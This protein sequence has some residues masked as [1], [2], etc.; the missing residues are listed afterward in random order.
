MEKVIA[1]LKETW[2]LYIIAIWMIGV[3]GFLVQ[4]NGRFDRLQQRV[5]KLVSDVDAIESILASTDH[6][7]AEVKKTV[8]ALAPQI[9]T[10]HKRVMRR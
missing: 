2:K 5:L 6:N 4:L 7:V 9:V 10:M 3:T 1:H 8:D